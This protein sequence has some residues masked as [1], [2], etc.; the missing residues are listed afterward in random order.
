[1]RPT[2]LTQFAGSPVA[3]QRGH[4]DIAL[5]TCVS[6]CVSVLCNCMDGIS[7][8]CHF[9]NKSY[10]GATLTMRHFGDGSMFTI[11]HCLARAMYLEAAAVA[12]SP[13]S[14]LP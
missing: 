6:S 14:C 8:A 13:M 2:R 1:M 9:G 3:A 7:Q 12:H 4:V 10:M 5:T 11:F